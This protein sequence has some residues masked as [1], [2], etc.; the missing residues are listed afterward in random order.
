[1]ALTKMVDGVEIPLTIEEESAILEEWALHDKLKAE[2]QYLDDRLQAYPPL[3]DQLDALWKI[4]NANTFIIP[5]DAQVINDTITD[6]K[7]TYPEPTLTK[8]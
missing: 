1:M 6:V 2:T 3:G 4:V 8:E 5:L 7:I